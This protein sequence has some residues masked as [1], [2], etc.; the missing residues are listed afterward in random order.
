MERHYRKLL[1]AIFIAG[2]SLCCIYIFFWAPTA[3]PPP[4][5]LEEQRG[6]I[7]GGQNSHGNS[8]PEQNEEQLNQYLM[9]D[10]ETRRLLP[11][12]FERIK[13][14]E[15]FKRK[16]LYDR[17][18]PDGHYLVLSIP[19]F[20]ESELAT[21]F[22]TLSE[23][24]TKYKDDKSLY[25]KVRTSGEALIQRYT[26]YP[27]HYKV[28]HIYAPTSSDRKISFMEYFLDTEQRGK[29]A[30]NGDFRLPLADEASYRSDAK[31][32]MAGSWATDRYSHLI[33]LGGH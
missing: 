4:S 14:I 11:S 28:L 13:T 31:F 26:N 10:D 18:S 22:I 33:D 6:S 8:A 21:I 27:K 15:S 12:T 17:Q 5:S 2:F 32:G 16:V 30:E 24:L 25:N 19:S 20:E 3:L 29:P 9:R 1:A 7:K 23:D